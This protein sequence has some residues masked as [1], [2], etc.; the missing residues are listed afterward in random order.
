ML[1]KIVFLQS[2]CFHI[3][4]AMAITQMNHEAAIYC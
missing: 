1:V 4:F 3:Y 2:I